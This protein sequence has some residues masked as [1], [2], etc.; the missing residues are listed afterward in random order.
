MMNTDFTGFSPH[1]KMEMKHSRSKFSDAYRPNTTQL[2]KVDMNYRGGVIH[3]NLGERLISEHLSE[4][5][6]H[7]NSSDRDYGAFPNMFNFYVTFGGIGR[8]KDKKF[9]PDGTY[10]ETIYE[11]QPT[12]KIARKFKNI[13]YIKLNHVI[14]PKTTVVDK[15]TGSDG[16]PEYALGDSYTDICSNY[17]YLMLKIKNIG[18]NKVFSTNDQVDEDT[19]ILYPDRMMGSQHYMWLPTITSRV[20]SNSSLA[21]VDKLTFELLDDEGELLFVLDTDGSRF[22]TKTVLA[23]METDRDETDP[24]LINFKR[25]HK[26]MQMDIELTFGVIEGELNTDIKFSS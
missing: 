13:K 26:M 1:S 2:G 12:P 17:K 21:N 9:K 22:N 7:I 3:N 4:Y 18:N 23:E 10:T 24:V 25:I 14:L 19:F 8:T 6:I 15:I 11:G 5:T 16:L 20:F